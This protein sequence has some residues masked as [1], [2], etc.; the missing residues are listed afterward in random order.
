[1]SRPS[2]PNELK[3]TGPDKAGVPPL[4]SSG[5]EFNIDAAGFAQ[6]DLTQFKGRCDSWKS[7]SIADV[8]KD[9]GRMV[10][11]LVQEVVETDRS[12]MVAH[13]RCTIAAQLEEISH[14]ATDDIQ[15]AWLNEENSTQLFI[16]NPFLS[17]ISN[18]YFSISGTT[19]STIT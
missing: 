12:P 4:L 16:I 19:A 8:R 5:K 18:S 6:L 10:L 15:T 3:S 11:Q 1:M 2:D 17:L 9:L 14:K 13:K 7:L